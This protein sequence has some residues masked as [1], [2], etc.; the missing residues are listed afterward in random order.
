MNGILGICMIFFLKLV[1]LGLVVVK[2]YI[3]WLCFF[4]LFFKVLIEVV[5]L[6]ICGKYVL[7]KKLIFIFIIFILFNNNCF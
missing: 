6:F 3:L 5:I 4:N 7:V 2:I 1:V